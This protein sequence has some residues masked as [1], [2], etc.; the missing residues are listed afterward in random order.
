MFLFVSC[1]HYIVILHYTKNYHTKVSHFS[2]IYHCTSLYNPITSGISAN[3]TL[4]V[5]FSAMLE[6]PTAGNLN[7]QF[8]VDPNSI[9]SIINFVQIRP[10]VLELNHVER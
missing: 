8:Y 10:V 1:S 3:P 9:T 6:L 2:K 5:H 7:V 4:Q